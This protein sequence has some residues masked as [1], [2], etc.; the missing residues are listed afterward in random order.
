[1]YVLILLY[2]CPHTISQALSAYIYLGDLVHQGPPA[3]AWSVCVCIM[4]YNVCVCVCVCVCV[5]HNTPTHT[6]CLYACMHTHLGNLMDEVAFGI[7]HLQAERVIDREP[8]QL[9]RHL[10]KQK[11]NHTPHTTHH[12]PHHTTHTL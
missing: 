6:L 5:Y 3:R 4:I 1:M 10:K 7:K 8:R 9:R 2:M 11:K 12:T